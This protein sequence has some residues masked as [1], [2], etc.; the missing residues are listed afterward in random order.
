M[1]EKWTRARATKFLKANGVEV[2]SKRIIAK[3]GYNGL[4]SCSARD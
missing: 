3:H 2:T 1:N 4:V